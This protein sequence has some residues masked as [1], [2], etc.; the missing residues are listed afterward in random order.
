MLKQ[1]TSDIQKGQKRIWAFLIIIIC[2]FSLAIAI[3]CKEGDA[4]LEARI[5]RIEAGLIP[6]PG[7]VIEGQPVPKASLVDRMADYKVPGISIAVIDKH[8]IESLPTI[9]VRRR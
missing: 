8:A 2:A 6:Q 1:E 4:K 3:G 7:I 5:Q 9:P